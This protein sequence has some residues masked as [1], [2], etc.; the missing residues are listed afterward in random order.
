MGVVKKKNLAFHMYTKIV[1][2]QSGKKERKNENSRI[3]RGDIS[4]K[5]S[6]V[7]TFCFRGSAVRRKCRKETSFSLPLFFDLISVFFFDKVS[8]AFIN[9]RVVPNELY[10]IPPC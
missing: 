4:S 10:I 7:L 1:F 5:F 6:S 9:V 8:F 2:A 3:L